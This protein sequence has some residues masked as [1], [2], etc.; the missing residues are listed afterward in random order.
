ML[1]LVV[2][3]SGSR[4]FTEKT[5]VRGSVV[6]IQPRFFQNSS[7]AT[8]REYTVNK[9]VQ[10]G[11]ELSLRLACHSQIPYYSKLIITF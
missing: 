2:P 7:M 8:N 11:Y 5:T 6:R 9:L 10:V 1:S 4:K 3:N